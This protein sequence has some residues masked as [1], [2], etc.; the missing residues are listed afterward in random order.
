MEGLPKRYYRNAVH[1]VYYQAL[2]ELGPFRKDGQNSQ[3]V[4]VCVLKFHKLTEGVTL[5]H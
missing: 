1:E 5:N 4:S 2:M 3:D